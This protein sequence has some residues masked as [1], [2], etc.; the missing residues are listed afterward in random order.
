MDGPL[1]K[2]ENF[3]FKDSNQTKVL[4]IFLV[5]FSHN[6]AKLFNV[7][8][9]FVFSKMATKID[10]IFTIDLTCQ[11]RG[12]DSIFF[13]AFLENMNFILNGKFSRDIWFY[14]E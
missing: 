11:I 8:L 5:V 4:F 3:K 2:V 6:A 10:K 1:D 12:E 7:H 14:L 9:K 13:L